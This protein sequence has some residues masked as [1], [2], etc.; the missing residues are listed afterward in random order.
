MSDGPTRAISDSPAELRRR[1]VLEALGEYEGRLMRYALRLLG[2]ADLARD[3]VQ[4]AFLKLCGQLVGPDGPA[5]LGLC[6]GV[7]SLTE[8]P[9]GGRSLHNRLAAWLFTVCR[10][11]ATDL[12]RTHARERQAEVDPGDH[13]TD[14]GADPA[15]R[16]EEADL[17]E[18]LRRLIRRLPLSQREAIDLW[19]EGFTYAE[20]ARI[21][22]RH[23]GH[24]RVLVHRGL[25][26]LREESQVRE[27]LEVCP[28]GPVGHTRSQAPLGTTRVE[29][30]LR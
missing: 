3:A 6:S 29:A 26:A 7:A 9:P 5:G 21:V 20:I 19:A 24:V 13:V 22:E 18:L 12:L 11:R 14:S 15:C 16:A 28:A 8:A 30:P 2:D 27:L 1:W 17:H 10:N 4:H 23:E 25:K